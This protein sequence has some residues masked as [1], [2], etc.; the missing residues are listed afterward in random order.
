MT[1]VR[2]HKYRKKPCISRR[3]LFTLKKIFGGGGTDYILR[4]VLRNFFQDVGCDGTYISEDI[5]LEVRVHI[6]SIVPTLEQF[7]CYIY[8]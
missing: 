3:N 1:G 7:H 6:Q 2:L 8:V 4:Y 5:D